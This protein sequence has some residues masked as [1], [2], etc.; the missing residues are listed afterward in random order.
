M[1]QES[2][3]DALVNLSEVRGRVGRLKKEDL[4][5]TDESSYVEDVHEYCAFANE[6][7]PDFRGDAWIKLTQVTRLIAREDGSVCQR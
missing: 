5:C 1:L 7:G 6:D 3:V 2:R 4:V